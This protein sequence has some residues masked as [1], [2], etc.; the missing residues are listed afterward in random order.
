MRWKGKRNEQRLYIFKFQRHGNCHV[1][2]Y[3][4]PKSKGVPE[5]KDLIT[6][7]R[8]IEAAHGIQGN[9]NETA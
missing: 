8:A 4:L 7:A 6:Q 1:F 9:A 3:V 2:C 5:M